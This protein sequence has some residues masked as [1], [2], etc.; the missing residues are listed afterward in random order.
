MTQSYK[1]TQKGKHKYCWRQYDNNYR[2]LSWLSL[3]SLVASIPW[4]KGIWLNKIY[5]PGHSIRLHA[6]CSLRSPAHSLPP[7]TGLGLVH[8]RVRSWKPLP[9]V[10]EQLEKSLQSE[11][12]PSTKIVNLKNC[13]FM[14]SKNASS[15]MVF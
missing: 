5:S 15:N 14:I 11:N 2:E 10:D 13:K 8:A 9:Q 1:V 4:K 6:F 7:C 3:S 12:P